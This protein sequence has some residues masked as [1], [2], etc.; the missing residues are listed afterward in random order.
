MRLSFTLV[1]RPRVSRQLQEL[2]SELGGSAMAT[3]LEAAALPLENRWKENIRN[4]PLVR[5]GTY[6]RSVHHNAPEMSG[7]GGTV[8][9]GTD[10][11]DPPYPAF[12]E[13]G[14]SKMSAKPTARPALDES[15]EEM[16]S[17]FEAVLKQQLRGAR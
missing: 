9:V 15:G 17:E 1:G 13:F 6:L 8:E 10:I 12:L 11:V 4:Y 3:A 14:T 2:R 16:R 7:D 5:T